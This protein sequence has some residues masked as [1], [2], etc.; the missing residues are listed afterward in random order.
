MTE[1][2]YFLSCEER[3]PSELLDTVYINQIGKDQQGFFDVFRTKVLSQ[4]WT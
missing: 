1:F 4:F 2:G 3:T